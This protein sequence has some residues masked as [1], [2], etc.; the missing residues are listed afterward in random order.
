MAFT[1]FLLV[2]LLGGLTFFPLLALV[3]LSYSYYYLPSTH[4]VTPNTGTIVS[5]NER[6]RELEEK[7]SKQSPEPDSAKGYFAVCRNFVPGGVNGKPPERTTPTGETVTADS[8]S[9]YQSMYRSIFERGKGQ[10]P[11]IDA[12]KAPPRG[13]NIFFVTMRYLP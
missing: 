9:V 11:S 13:R 1:A 2:Y 7:L 5:E 4:A 3:I 10:Q 8:P 6:D 12:G